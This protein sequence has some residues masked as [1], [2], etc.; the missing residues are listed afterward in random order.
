MRASIKIRMLLTSTFV[1]CFSY[2]FAQVRICNCLENL[3][4][5]VEETEV[6]YA[7]YPARLRTAGALKYQQHVQRLKRMATGEANPK[8]CFYVLSEYINFFR[9]KHFNLSYRNKADFDSVV[10]NVNQDYWQQAYHHKK[11]AP[12]EGIWVNP[13]RTV[14]LGIRRT[15]KGSYQAIKLESSVDAYPTGFVY[16]TLQPKG[17]QFVVKEYDAFLS[18][19]TPA[20]L[21]GNLLQLWNHAIW[22]RVYPYTLSDSERI[23]LNSW[24][25]GNNGLAFRKLDAQTAYLKIPTFYNNDDKIQSLVAVNDSVIRNTK[26][27]VVDLT[28]NGGGNTGWI[29]FL[30]YF[31][32]NPILQQPS[33]LRV[34]PEN[35]KRKLP[36]L[37]PYVSG[38]IPDEYKKYFPQE[39]LAKYKQ[40]YQDLPVT[41]ESYYPIPGVTFPLD[42]ITQYPE[43]I[44]LVVD[45][46]GGSSTEYFLFLSRQSKKSISYGT[47]TIGMMDYEGMSNPTPLPYDQFILTIPIAQSSWTDKDPVNEKG[48]Q[49]DVLL[50]IPQN[51]WMSAILRD[52]KKR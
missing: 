13:D 52:L 9:D 19:A 32:T 6:N 24:Q 27:L 11:L 42:S 26:Y 12:V 20:K 3:Q 16:F 4:K 7:G 36:D 44:A 21:N 40:A 43:K 2:L 15:S 10:V 31:I 50:N 51:H 22:G 1:M 8:K 33:L 30:P 25:D 39:V 38:P 41:K 49:P 18:A 47:H 46:M 17:N 23:E 29:Y 37:E 35:V 34:T 45:Q 5:T 28:G 48:F 14:K